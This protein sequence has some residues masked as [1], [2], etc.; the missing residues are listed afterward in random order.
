MAEAIYQGISLDEETWGN[1][2]KWTDF[3]FIALFSLMNSRGCGRGVAYSCSCVIVVEIFVKI[4]C[5]RR[6]FSSLEENTC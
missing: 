5:S 4:Y 1:R 3:V 2:G 6:F